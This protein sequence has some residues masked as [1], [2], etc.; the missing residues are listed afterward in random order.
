[1]VLKKLKPEMTVYDVRPSTGLSVFN[2][3]WSIWSIVIKE[4][5]IEKIVYWRH[6]V[7]IL[8]NGTENLYGKNGD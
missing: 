8:L 3:R 7:E 6:G 4:I 2:G 5:D 1:M